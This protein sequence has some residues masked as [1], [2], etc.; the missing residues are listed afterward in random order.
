MYG[1]MIYKEKHLIFIEYEI[2]QYISIHCCMLILKFL[3]VM[4]LAFNV[5][6]TKWQAWSRLHFPDTRLAIVAL[7]HSSFAPRRRPDRPE[8]PR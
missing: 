1:S 4:K 7:G 3:P 5:K 2:I 8:G 6:C